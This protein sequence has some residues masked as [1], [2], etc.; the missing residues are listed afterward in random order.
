MIQAESSTMYNAYKVYMK[1]TSDKFIS[2][3]H[4]TFNTN[5]RLMLT[6]IKQDVESSF[7]LAK[8]M[9]EMNKPITSAITLVDAKIK[10]ITKE[11]T[12]LTMDQKKERCQLACKAFKT[13]ACTQNLN[14]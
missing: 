4:K 11:A 6:N 10:K 13:P 8:E 5:I 3:A 9:K 14:S 1:Q 12:T 2:A 7:N